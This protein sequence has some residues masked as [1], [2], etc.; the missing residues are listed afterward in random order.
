MRDIL[1]TFKLTVRYL[2]RHAADEAVQQAIC[3]RLLELVTPPSL[4]L[5]SGDGN[6]ANDNAVAPPEWQYVSHQQTKRWLAASRSSE[7]GNGS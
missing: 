1:R 7:G 2:I 3:G 6:K 5:S 4:R